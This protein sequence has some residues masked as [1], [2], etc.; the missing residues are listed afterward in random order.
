[1]SAT[2]QRK[3]DRKADI[4][5]HLAS[6]LESEPGA[7][8][9]TAKLAQAVGVSEAA[10]YRHF[11]SKAKMFEALIVYAEDIIFDRVAR[12][13]SE[14]PTAWTKTSQIIALVLTFCERNP[15]IARLLSGDALLGEAPRLR[16]RAAQVF[17][18]LET[19]IRQIFREANLNQEPEGLLSPSV[20]ASLALTLIEGRLARFVRSDFSLKP[21]DTL[22]PQIDVLSQLFGHAAAQH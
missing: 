9:T 5:N 1:M 14:Q 20:S 15:G 6:M 4:L 7:R 21:T 2:A 17:E 16:L 8:L 22:D 3:Q 10:L 12:I 13:I 11:A 19:Q 18:R